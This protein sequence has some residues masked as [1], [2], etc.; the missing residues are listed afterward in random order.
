MD[1]PGYYEFYSR[2]RIISGH[3][4]L[5]RIPDTLADLCAK[6]PLIITDRGVSDAGLLGVVTDAL[7]GHVTIGDVADDVP[8]DSDVRIVNR[9]ADTYRQK[10]CDSIIAI[11]GGSVMDTAKGVNIVVSENA[12]DLMKFSGAGVLKKALKPLIVI[13]TTAGTG[14][15]VTLVSVIKDHEKHLKMTFVSY[16]L[17]PDAAILDSRMTTTLPPMMTAATAMDAMTHAV[18]AYTGLAK[19]PLSDSCALA[20]IRLISDN[21]L[22]VMNNPGDKD[23]RLAL[24]NAA[25]MAGM[26]P[27]RTVL[28]RG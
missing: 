4:A 25:T 18:E 22:K 10:N 26:A 9:L 16:F 20:A 12:D 7:T 27:M 15:E 13:P 8:Q 19:N 1:V 5:D 3:N 21:L 17:L 28:G 24:A 6:I 2:V 14:S 23:G 11:G